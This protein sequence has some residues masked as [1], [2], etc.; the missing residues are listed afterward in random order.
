MFFETQNYGCLDP[1]CGLKMLGKYEML[2][3][4]IFLFVY[5]S[6]NAHSNNTSTMQ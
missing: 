1:L 5:L 6:V 4:V 2:S 3:N